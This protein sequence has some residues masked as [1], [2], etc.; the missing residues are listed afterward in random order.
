MATL[1]LLLCA[2]QPRTARELSKILN[3]NVDYVRND[4]L[5]PLVQ[6]GQ[7]DLT[8]AANDPNVAYRTTNTL[9]DS[10]KK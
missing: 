10:G 3:R 8:G 5:S 2:E 6:K 7:L 4:Y 9:G 1:V